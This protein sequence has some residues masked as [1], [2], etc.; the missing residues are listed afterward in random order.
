MASKREPIK[1]E[2][3]FSANIAA[4]KILF[5]ANQILA[6]WFSKASDKRLETIVCDEEPDEKIQDPGATPAP[7]LNADQLRVFVE[8]QKLYVKQQTDL[9]ELASYMRETITEDTYHLLA[10]STGSSLTAHLDARE[11]YLE[12]AKTYV[13]VCEENLTHVVA[14]L[15]APFVKGTS[16]TMH[17]LE[18]LKC[19]EQITQARGS[20]SNDAKIDDLVETL[21]EINTADTHRRTI[22]EVRDES[23]DERRENPE[24]AFAIFTKT[25]LAFDR[26]KRFGSAS[27]MPNDRSHGNIHFKVDVSTNKLDMVKE[28]VPESQMDKLLKLMETIVTAKTGGGNTRSK[29]VFSKRAVEAAREKHK[30]HD[31]DAGCPVHPGNPPRFPPGHTWKTCSYYTGI[32]FKP[33]GKKN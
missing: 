4:D 20:I 14:K 31:L 26:N 22:R 9:A 27:A 1:E 32:E 21:M 2:E 24:K 25:L 15:R 17:V 33:K 7:N 3:K 19:R 23:E 5:A 29:P 12:F 10:L 11:L 28:S 8:T 18:H 30:D 16:L 13:V 6:K